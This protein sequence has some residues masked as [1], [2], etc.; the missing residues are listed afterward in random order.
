MVILVEKE[1]DSVVQADLLDFGDIVRIPHGASPP[2]D[3][4]IIQGES[5]FDESS[6]TG[7]S[8]PVKKRP[9]NKVF[10][11]TIN[12]D[13]AVLIQITGAADKS[14]LDQIVDV[15]RDGQ[16]KRAPM[17]RIADKLTAH[18]VP[19]ITLIA[20]ITWLIWMS[21]GLS[22]MVPKDWLNVSSGIWVA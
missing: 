13:S 5:N 8:R 21:L 15:V 16:T 6:L 10:S 11:G 2:G 14:M 9:G 20:I 17:E 7:E 4:I 22:G 3:G 18:F 1:S 12:K 19:A